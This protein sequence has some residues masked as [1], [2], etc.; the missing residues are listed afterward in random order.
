MTAWLA[1]EERYN[2]TNKELRR[3]LSEKLTTRTLTREEDP[4][5]FLYEMHRWKTSWNRLPAE[6]DYV[7][8]KS[9]SDL[10]SIRRTINDIFIDD[11]SRANHTGTDSDAG[12]GAAM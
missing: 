12:R 8:N 10:E 5:D 4:Q 6:Y 9:Y 3:S 11:L 2:N 1:L 7:E